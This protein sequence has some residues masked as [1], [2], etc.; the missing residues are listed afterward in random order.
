MP[1]LNP[2]IDIFIFWGNGAF[3]VQWL[4]YIETHIGFS[5]LMTV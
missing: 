1:G 3:Y 5:L 4:G 2:G